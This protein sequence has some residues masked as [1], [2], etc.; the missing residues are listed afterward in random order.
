MPATLLLPFRRVIPAAILFGVGLSLCSV[1]FADTPESTRAGLNRQFEE[2]VEPFL[3]SYC[4]DCHGNETQ[5]AKLDLSG[6]T[7]ADVVSSSHATWTIVL[8]RL[9]AG[10]MPPG[11][12]NSQPASTERSSVIKWI[13]ALRTYDANRHAGDPGPVLARRL[14]NAEYDY[15]IRD[16]TGVDIHPTRTFP[17]DPANE[18]GFDNTGES[19]TMSPALLKKYLDAARQVAEH[20]VLTPT[21]LM[22]APHPVMTDT[23]RDK[24]CVKRIIEFY[25]RQPTELA[26]YLFVCWQHRRQ[27]DRDLTSFAVQEG[28]SAKYANSVWDLLNEPTPFGPIARLQSMFEALPD[29]ADSSDAFVAC[30]AMRDYVLELRPK[31]SPKFENLYI[32]GNHKG[33]QPFVL[34]KD[35]QYAA[36]RRKFDRGELF[37][38]GNEIPDGTPR[39]L[40]LSNDEAEQVRQLASIDRFCS[41]FPDAFFI[42]ER[43]RDYLGVAKEQQETGRLLSAGFHSMMG[44]FRDDG[45]LYELILGEDGRR[46]L[47][48]LWQELDFVASAPARQYVGFLWFE[49]TDSRYM[50]DEVFD[51][52]RAE[53]KNA[54]SEA[55]VKKLADVYL[56]KARRSGGS[57]VALQAIEDFFTNI[58]AQLRWVET[59]RSKSEPIHVGL[60]VQFAQQAWRRKL[61]PDEAK[62]IREFY[63]LLRDV[64]HLDHEEAVRDSMVSIL[65]S[66]HFLYRMDL[67]S[68]GEGT[69]PLTGA[70]M[71]SRLSYF[72]WS[73]PPDDELRSLPSDWPSNPGLVAQQAKRL[74]GDERIRGLATEFAANWL[75]FRRFDT[76]NSVD[77]ERFPEFTDELRQAMFE[78]PIRFFTHLVQRDRPVL[79]LLNAN[80]TFVNPVLARHYGIDGLDDF[81]DVW[82]R[83]EDAHEHDR[84]G[85]L[86]MSAFLTMNAPGLRT[87][88]VKR[89]YWV[90]RRLLGERIPPPPPNVPE[91]PADE[92]SLGDL[93]LPELLARHRDNKSCAGCHDRFDAIGLAFEG[94]GPVGERREKDLGGRAV[95]NT[96]V[97]PNGDE[98]TGI[99]GLRKY[100]REHRQQEFI[101]NLCRKLLSYGLGRSLMLSDEPLV[102]K[103]QTQLEADDFR[104]SSLVESIVTSPQFLNKRGSEQLVKDH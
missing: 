17:V 87:S 14:S 81:G 52:A 84:G 94:F 104:F 96:A 4:R 20:L 75:D 60:L 99:A 35:R 32:E 101:A 1:I 51:F 45:P 64:D 13:R 37:I 91:L 69:R 71:A 18:A 49:R 6:Y 68:A 48:R 95:E 24:Y 66:P 40:V 9:E 11:D 15:T 63:R 85:L 92:S 67:A 21:D 22:F 83:V 76:H 70:E 12:S 93:T 26:S 29:G 39:E 56:E 86:P 31:L 97:F 98:G 62:G 59:E 89:G 5:E 88:P 79:E 16:L 54:A 90:V 30:E 72:L 73:A 102:A 78:E 65:M 53:D 58:N 7:S 2:L 42:S 50:R 25:E 27:P 23:D 82:V 77:R 55:M 10:E 47:D 57:D 74:L 3:S 8:E 103:M 100:L 19:L 34:W 28:I 38:E 61:L 33:S 41:V 44:Y 80:Y 43:G 36:H 46:T